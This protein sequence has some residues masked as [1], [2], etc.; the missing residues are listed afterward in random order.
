MPATPKLVLV[1]LAD[2]ANDA[3]VCWPSVAS[4]ERRTGLS[5]R[6]IQKA[7]QW[8]AQA[9][10]LTVKRETGKANFFTVTPE[11]YSPPTPERRSP[12]NVVPPEPH[13][14]TPERRSPPPPNHVHHTPEP[15]S[16]RTVIETSI[17]PS[18]TVKAR[19]RAGTLAATDLVALGVDPVHA[20]DWITARKSPITET[21]WSDLQREAGKAGITAAEAVRICAVKGW[22]GFNAGWKW[23]DA[24]PAAT[25][26]HRTVAGETPEQTAAR[27]AEAK[28]LA[29]GGATTGDVIDA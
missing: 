19:K 26:P 22:R 10:A 8:L 25:V 21:A 27:R 18:G 17:E 20:R 5:D 15:R 12:P 4:I 1:S 29:F 3:G 24:A 28:R 6:A 13:S 23:Q 9:G 2:Q 7:L 14:P 16:P 11:R